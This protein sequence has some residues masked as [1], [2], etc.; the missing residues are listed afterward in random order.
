LTEAV[1]RRYLPLL[2]TLAAIWGASFAFIEVA[3]DDLTP[4][5][6]VAARVAIAAVCLLGVLAAMHGIAGAGRAL[7]GA[8]LGPY[9]LGIVNSALPFTLIAWGQEH[10]DSGTAAI[11]NAST[12]I[13]VALLAIWFWQGE[14]ATGARLAGILL[15]LAG[16]GVLT[17]AQPNA[18]WSTL[19]GTLAVVAASFSYAISLLIA[20]HRMWGV[21]PLLL[22][23]TTMIGATVVLLPFAL[24]QLPDAAP[25]MEAVAAVL[26]LAIAGTAVALLLYFRLMVGYG[27]ARAALVTY[28]V[29]VTALAYG[30]LFLDEPITIA[31][32]AGMGLVLAGVGLGSGMVR[33]PRREPAVAAPRA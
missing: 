21:G 5:T 2:L 10:V 29:P 9:A 18:S 24:L 15:G 7:R 20:Q 30:A 28:V 26:A 25:G 23:T 3:L 11:A 33:L 19:V 8:G 16:V 32:L 27:S 31:K 13:W 14:R 22:S 6:L 1:T 17:G 12:P 4:T